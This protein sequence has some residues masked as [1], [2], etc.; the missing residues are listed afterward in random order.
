MLSRIWAT[1]TMAALLASVS[2][3]PVVLSAQIGGFRAARTPR[4]LGQCRP[5]PSIALGGPGALVLAR[6]LIA[7]RTETRPRREIR[8]TLEDRARMRYSHGSLHA[9]GRQAGA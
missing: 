7:A 2:G 4:R 6:A 8:C 3:Y 5:E 9:L 1:A